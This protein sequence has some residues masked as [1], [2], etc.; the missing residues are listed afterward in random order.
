[1]VPEQ[2][3]APLT[4]GSLALAQQPANVVEFVPRLSVVPEPKGKSKAGKPKGKTIST[5]EE[6][7]WLKA[8]FPAKLPNATGTWAV[9]NSGAGFV[10][11]FRIDK[12]Q[13]IGNTTIPRP[14]YLEGLDLSIKGMPELVLEKYRGTSEFS[15]VEAYLTEY[16]NPKP[17]NVHF[18]RISREMFIT[19]KGM[20]NEQAKRRINEYVGA[21][22]ESLIELGDAR[23]RTVAEKLSASA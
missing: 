15:E 11:V 19:L 20:N 9:T 1:M 17:V 14:R 21:T 4:H 12:R 8:R 13:N 16:Q 10:V 6:C 7:D 18:P 5:K 23:G 2:T 3:A 22:L